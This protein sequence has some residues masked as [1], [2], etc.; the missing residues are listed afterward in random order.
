V[1]TV[2]ADA[3]SINLVG[4]AV[5]DPAALIDLARLEQTT[6]DFATV[7]KLFDRGLRSNPMQVAPAVVPGSFSALYPNSPAV[8]FAASSAT[9]TV[10]LG[11]RVEASRTTTVKVT[12]IIK[13]AASRA[14]TQGNVDLNLFFVG[15]QGLDATRARTDARF[16]QILDRVRGVWSKVGVGLGTVSYID[17]GGA[18]AARFSDL[19]QDDLGALMTRSRNPAA[20]DNALNVFFVNTIMGDG[21][22]GYIILGESAGIPG[23][24][25]R[26]TTG[27][28]MAVTTADF[29]A[30]LDD[31]ADTLAHEGGHFLGLFHTTE[32]GGTAF[33]PLSDT[34]ECARAQHDRNGDRIMQPSECKALD[35]GDVMFWT[36][37][38][39]IPNSKLT[40][41]Q[42][43]VM[44]RNP[45]V[46]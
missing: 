17:L 38:P 25:I 39:E 8:P 9:T 45:A 13:R 32:L 4:E 30:G 21:L 18:D 16:Q 20:R 3:V 35:G 12:A 36:S 42:G 34:P 26:G 27:S 37:A 44:L 15:L 14:L 6:N 28:G 19:S 29:P 7:T 46:H 10:K 22:A 31:I 23:V 11:L 5:S 24:P 40:P 1:V 33:D 41:H 43:F 2:P